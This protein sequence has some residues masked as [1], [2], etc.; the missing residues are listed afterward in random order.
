MVKSSDKLTCSGCEK[1]VKPAL[2]IAHLTRCKPSQELSEDTE[3]EK[4]NIKVTSIDGDQV[5]SIVCIA[6]MRWLVKFS[7][8]DFSTRVLPHLE[9]QFPS[10]DFFKSGIYLSFKKVGNEGNMLE[11]ISE[12]LKELQLLHVVAQDKTFRNMFE[13]QKH[14]EASPE[15]V[16]KYLVSNQ[17]QSKMG[18]DKTNTQEGRTISFFS[19]T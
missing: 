7:L 13:I 16:S 9:S 18:T 2:F 11:Q 17:E 6:N 15:E 14:L 19:R 10:A 5:S 1:Q 3:F 8:N 12:V 4:L